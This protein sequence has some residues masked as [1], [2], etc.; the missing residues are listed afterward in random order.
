MGRCTLEMTPEFDVA[1]VG[2]G[3]A[4][5]AAGI[6]LAHAGRRVVILERSTYSTARVGETLPPDVRLLLQRLGVWSRF[7]GGGH[8]PT[9]GVAAAWGQTEPYTNDFIVNPYGPGWR[10]DRMRF[11][12]MLAT[13]A[14]EAGAVVC[15]RTKVRRCY[16][17]ASGGWRL[18]A[19]RDGQPL[20][21]L[22]S[23]FLIDATGR[24]PTL[25]RHLGARRIVHDRLVGLVRFMAPASAVDSPDL[26][27]LVEATEHGWWYSAWLPDR[28]LVVALHTDAVPGLR[29]QW[30]THLASAPHTS[31]RTAGMRPE[32]L[33][34]LPANSQLRRPIGTRTWLAVG[35]AAAAHDPITGLGVYWALKSGIAAGDALATPTSDRASEIEAYAQ[36]VHEQFELYLT[37][38]AIYY[39]AEQRW[40]DSPFWKCRHA[41][42]PRP[43]PAAQ[44]PASRLQAGC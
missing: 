13:A 39:Q 15:R 12:D 35:D 30:L 2:G 32:Q 20:R 34:V 18:G 14:A 43:L 3:P 25:W 9:P 16:R 24:T 17:E 28:R 1:I 36:A 6:V 44:P 37:Q 31:A 7:C 26:R 38:R 22:S 8:A 5:C 11:D 19:S 4:G 21:P 27:A 40:P 29:A 41:D 42:P 33:R 10:I 23:A